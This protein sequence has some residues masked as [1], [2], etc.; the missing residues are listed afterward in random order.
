[1]VYNFFDK[2]TSAMRTNKFASSGIK[3]ENMSDQ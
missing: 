2:K 1:M 3:N